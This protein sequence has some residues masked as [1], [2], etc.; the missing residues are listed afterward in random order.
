MNKLQ[1]V[2]AMLL[3]ASL[4]PISALASSHREAPEI[5]GLPRVDGTDFS[6]HADSGFAQRAEWSARRDRLVAVR[7][8]S[9]ELTQAMSRQGSPGWA[10]PA[11]D[12][13]RRRADGTARPIFFAYPSRPARAPFAAARGSTR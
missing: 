8:V 2:G 9:R 7:F 6:E 5:A 12:A 10:A 1:P 3:G 13:R 4:L 11:P